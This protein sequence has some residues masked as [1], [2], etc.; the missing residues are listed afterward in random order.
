M[1]IRSIGWFV[2]DLGGLPGVGWF[3]PLCPSCTLW[4]ITSVCVSAL[5]GLG[6]LGV[7]SDCVGIVLAGDS[8]ITGIHDNWCYCRY[9]G[10]S[11]VGVFT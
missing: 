1:D 11:G 7:V 6:G 3:V 8:D 4:A 5:P 9:S 10:I 2:S